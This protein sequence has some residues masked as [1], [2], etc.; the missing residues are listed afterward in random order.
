VIYRHQTV[1]KDKLLGR[2]EVDESYFGEKRRRGYH[3][4]LKGSQCKDQNKAT[5]KRKVFARRKSG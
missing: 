5:G 2:V 3:G 1:L 4:K